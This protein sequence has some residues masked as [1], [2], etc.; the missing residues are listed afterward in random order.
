MTTPLLRDQDTLDRTAGPGLGSLSKRVLLG[1]K[2]RSSQLGETLL[3]KRVAL[4]VF[5]DGFAS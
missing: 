4:P 3:P 1:R 5:A 2:L